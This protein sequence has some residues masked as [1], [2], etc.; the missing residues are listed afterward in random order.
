MPASRRL[1]PGGHAFP[2]GGESH[3][4]RASHALWFSG[5]PLHTYRSSSI[6]PVSQS[7]CTMR[8]S[9][10]SQVSMEIDTGT[11]NTLISEDTDMSLLIRPKPKP[12]AL[13]LR[14]YTGDPISVLGKFRTYV[15]YKG[16]SYAKMKAVLVQ[17]SRTSLLSWDRL[18]L[19]KLDWREGH[20]VG[21]DAGQAKVRKAILSSVVTRLGRTQVCKAS[22]G[23]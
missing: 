9:S 3:S 16:Q 12:S 8:L 17:G 10:T 6:L 15:V 11:C 2:A 23:H 22:S 21:S 4:G 19:I 13:N 14:T 18:R 5:P 20:S 1:S 7:T